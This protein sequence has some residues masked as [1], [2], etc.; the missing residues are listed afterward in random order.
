MVRMDTIKISVRNLFYRL[1]APFKAAYNNYRDDHGHYRELTQCDGVL[2]WTG[3]EIEVHLVPQ[4]NSPPKLH[5][6]TGQSL[7]CCNSFPK[8][9]R[10]K[11][12]LVTS[13]MEAMVNSHT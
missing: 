2:R 5:L 12:P 11:Q 7:R 6:I 8:P 3:S 1:F 13:R 4:V 9:K 10:K